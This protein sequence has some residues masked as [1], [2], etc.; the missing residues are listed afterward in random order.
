M[1]RPWTHEEI[2]TVLR[3][4]AMG[5]RDKDIEGHLEGRTFRAIRHAVLKHKRGR[6]KTRT[7][8]IN[9]LGPPLKACETELKLK[10]NAVTGSQAYDK[11][12]RALLSKM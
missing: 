8:S 3:L 5:M 12:I 10:R 1:S 9:D 7:P 6:L 2:A 11:A 4:R